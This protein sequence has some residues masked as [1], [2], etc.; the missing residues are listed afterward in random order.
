[1][2][3][4]LPA[5][6]ARAEEDDVLVEFHF[7]PVP[8]AQV[9]IWL[10]DADGNFVQDVFVTQATGRL[11]IGNR[12]GRWDFLSSWRFPYGPRTGVLP[13]WAHARDQ[14]YPQLTFHDDDPADQESL[15]WHEN[16]SSPEPYFCRPLAGSEHE[17]I[18]TDTMTCPSP[19]VFQSDKGRFDADKTSVYP[20]RN[21]LTTFED[22]HDSADVP[23]FS[24]INDLD[25]ITGA[26]P[27]G[28]RPELLTAVVPA[29]I[30]SQGPLVARIE[31]NLERD[32]NT[33]WDFSREGD[34]FVDPRLSSYGIEYMG[35]PSVVYQVGFDPRKAVFAGTD[36]YAGYGQLDGRDG[37]LYPPDNSISQSEG[38]GADRLQ[39]YTLNGE[40]FRFGVYSHGLGSGGTE[41]PPP[42]EDGWG[43]CT[44]SDLPGMTTVELET[45][46]F[47]TVRVHFT[48]PPQQ[49]DT[50]I[51]NVVLYYRQGQDAITDQNA[52]SAV[53]QV[54]SI[55]DCSG[56]IIP[57][58]PAWC[59]VD[60]LFGNYDYQ[61]GIA[62]E[63]VC[64]NISGISSGD[65]RT[66]AQ[67]FAQVDGLCFVAT[68]AW[69][70][71]WEGRVKALR[72]FRDQFL[73]TQ[74][75]GRA[76]VAFYYAHSPPLARMI[77]GQPVA[78]ALVRSMLEPVTDLARI[79]T[80]AP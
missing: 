19:A 9:A 78:R 16:T 77:A 75:M 60:E 35:Q 76:F 52:G 38:S 23:M 47:D 2:G 56:E 15:G 14:T 36:A 48:V 44:L 55:E 53:Q 42:N 1:M 20:P 54:P 69:G 30:A 46:D 24:Q 26:T 79:T 31:I 68:A 27:M 67:Q 5:S 40:T 72:W 8:D 73:K 70:A 50:R 66:P 22:G 43:S 11:G 17:T 3:L 29:E 13:V 62:Y 4:W 61:I 7:E 71:P 41:P 6:S 51:S 49:G 10:E 28:Y 33:D 65:I 80:G 45:V 37:T 39:L 64:G 32:E 21:D 74:P 18:A 12:P 58:E 63:D 59:E 34:H 57:G 25:A